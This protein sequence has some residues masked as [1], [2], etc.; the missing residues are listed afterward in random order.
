MQH[1]QW[2]QGTF[3]A[4]TVAGVKSRIDGGATGWLFS[5]D[6]SG[7]EGN[8][9]WFADGVFHDANFE[10]RCE[11]PFRFDLII[12]HQERASDLEPERMDA[13]LAAFSAWDKDPRTDIPESLSE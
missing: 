1:G 3:G 12:E 4:Y 10:S 9:H 2:I 6:V 11:S 13:L 5:S 7:S 8:I